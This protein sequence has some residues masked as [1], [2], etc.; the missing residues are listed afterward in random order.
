MTPE[1]LDNVVTMKIHQPRL[2]VIGCG[3]VGLRLVALLR[4]RYR[5][6]A[7]TRQAGQADAIR[8]AGA[9]P[10]V[11]DLDRPETLAR[12][13][14][15]A[16]RIVHLAPPPSEGE[17]DGRTRNLIPFLPRAARM[18]YVSTTGVYGD[19]AGEFVHE[20]RTAKPQNARAVRR[21]DAETRLRAWAAKSGSRLA[22]LRV[23]G[24]YAQERLPLER[25]RNGTPALRAEDD[26]FTNHIHADDLA[27]IIELAL[28]R[29]TPNRIYHASDDS[30]MKMGDYFDA[31]ARAYGMPVPPRLPREAL[32]AQVSPVLLS[33]MSES[34]RLD[35][36]RIKEEL[37]V[38]LRYR[39]V[40]SALA[41]F[42]GR[43]A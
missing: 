40:E 36:R 20:T 25:L 33:F 21:L 7:V 38:R 17:R 11:A 13:S 23:P 9:A 18:V 31:V 8:A 29:G 35:N 10:I 1:L 6:F 12:L 30:V 28:A 14:R 22:I 4:G 5:I 19:C 43:K 26:V 24:I 16:R 15:L 37:G 27:R 41:I 32:R 42:T 39:D 2:L 3:D 34:R